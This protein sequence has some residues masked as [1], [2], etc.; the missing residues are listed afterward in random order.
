VGE[1]EEEVARDRA[2]ER[3]EHH[4]PSP[5]ANRQPPRRGEKTNCMAEKS[6]GGAE[7]DR[8]R[9]VLLRVERQERDDDPEPDKVDEDGQEN[10]D[11]RGAS[12]TQLKDF[13]QPQPPE[14]FGFSTEKPAPRKSSMKSTVAPWSFVALV[15]STITSMSRTGTTKSEERFSSKVKPYWKPEQPPG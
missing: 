3:D 7:L 4:R 10:D 14:A 11:Q 6:P 9:P 12:R 13:P 2:G 1:G 15:G 8:R 5:D